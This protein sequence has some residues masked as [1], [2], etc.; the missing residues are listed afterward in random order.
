MCFN[1][2]SNRLIVIFNIKSAGNLYNVMDLV[3]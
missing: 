1:F 2:K 3:H